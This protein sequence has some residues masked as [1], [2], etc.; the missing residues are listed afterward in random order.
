MQGL[1]RLLNRTFVAH[2]IFEIRTN[3]ITLSVP[4]PT[5]TSEPNDYDEMD[6]TNKCYDTA[7]SDEE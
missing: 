6:K 4:E 1:P 3:R 2:I 7:D 5:T